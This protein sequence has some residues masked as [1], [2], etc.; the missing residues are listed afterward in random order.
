VSQPMNPTPFIETLPEVLRLEIIASE[1]GLAE[2]SSVLEKAGAAGYTV[3][4]NLQGWGDRG[5]QRGDEIDGI[6]GN[7]SIVCLCDE[8]TA[9]KVAKK[10][11]PLLAHRGGICAVTPARVLSK[12]VL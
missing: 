2:I 5:R 1:S 4:P 10:L 11:A 7:V 8:P 3:Y 6:S 12:K 9:A